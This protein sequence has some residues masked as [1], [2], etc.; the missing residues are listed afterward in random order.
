MVFREQLPSTG[1]YFSNILSW[2]FFYA[3]GLIGQWTA[4]HNNELDIN[5]MSHLFFTIYFFYQ[6]LILK[7]ER[8]AIVQSITFGKYE[9]THV[10]NL[11]KFKVFGGM[12]EDNMT[13]LLSRWDSIDQMYFIPF[14]KFKALLYFWF[15]YI[16][17]T[18][19]HALCTMIQPCIQ[20]F[21]MKR[22]CTV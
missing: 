20:I 10:C 21:K 13:E 15:Y 4:S 1:R 14:L 2:G 11:K 8:P 12:G 17:I 6:F 19:S 16:F 18:L 7:M 22:I 5:F 9:K 3:L